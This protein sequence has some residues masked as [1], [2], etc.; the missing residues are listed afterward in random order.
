RRIGVSLFPN[1]AKMEY[2]PEEWGTRPDDR[3]DTRTR[4]EKEADAR[5]TWS[6]WQGYLAKLSPSER[7]I[8]DF[9]MRHRFI[10]FQMGKL[11]RHGQ[12]FVNAM[13]SLD[14]VVRA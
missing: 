12:R 1:V 14:E 7:T 3:P 5:N 4:E 6:R 8:I 10:L 13:R 2:M 9:A 11:T